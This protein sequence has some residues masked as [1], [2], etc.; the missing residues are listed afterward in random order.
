MTAPC[1]VQWMMSG[2]RSLCHRPLSVRLAR[3]TG[4][5]LEAAAM[6]LTEPRARRKKRDNVRAFLPI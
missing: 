1:L 2:A 5:G 3:L 4:C 6:L